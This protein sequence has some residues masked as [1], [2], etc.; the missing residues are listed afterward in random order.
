[1][2]TVKGEYL[3]TDLGSETVWSVSELLL[4]GSV[5]SDIAFHTVRLG[6]NYKF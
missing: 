1:M 6:V 2:G 3:Y 4:E 5:D